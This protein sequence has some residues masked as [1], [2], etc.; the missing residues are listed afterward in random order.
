MSRI[1]VAVHGALGKVGMEVISSVS[2]DKSLSLVGAVDIRANSQ[3]LTAGKI[4]KVPLFKKTDDLLK[5][6]KPD[7]IVDFSIAEASMALIRTAAKSG[8]DLVVGTTGL[9]T[10]DKKEINQLAKGCNV[11]I[12]VSPN[13]ALGVVVLM[14]LCR[15]AAKYFDNAEIVEMHHDEK[16]DAPSG[17]A[18]ATAESMLE[19]RE[20]KGFNYPLTQKKKL[21]GIRGGQLEGMTIHSVRLPG[22]VAR[23]EVIFGTQGQTLQL[24]HDAIS[25][26]CYMP[27]VLLAVKEV[28]R[29]R[30]S[31]HNLEDLLKLG[32]K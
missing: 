30:G 3:Y 15:I 14:Y 18:L 9:T 11:G 10:R 4:K 2:N 13:F 29:Y 5:K 32:G 17:T 24:R 12:I 8:I 28:S 6:I 1:S 25:R 27:G 23:Q 21:T 7:V 20:G 31:V 26:E 22:L 16:V 19:A